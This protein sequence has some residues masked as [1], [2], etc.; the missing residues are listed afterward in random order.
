MKMQTDGRMRK[1]IKTT[2]KKNK[3]RIADKKNKIQIVRQK[4]QST[5]SPKGS[6]Y[7]VFACHVKRVCSHVT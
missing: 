3:M 4:E 6:K 1:K 2:D 5:T 7:S